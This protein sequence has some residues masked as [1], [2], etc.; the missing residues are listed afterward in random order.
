MAGLDPA[1]AFCHSP[2]MN[3]RHSYHAGNH[4]D[5][6][7]HIV[8]ARVIERLLRKDKPLRVIDAHA[9]AGLYD[10][11]GVEAGKT[12]EWQGGIGK[13][14]EE[15]AAPV[16]TLL[17]AYRKVVGELLSGRH[18]PGS[19]W[20]AAE[21]ARADD[22][23]VLNELHPEDRAALEDNFAGDRRVT[24]TGL[25]AEVCIKANLPPPERRGLILIDPPYEQRDEAQRAVRM[26]GQGIRRFATGC[27]I[28]WYPLKADD[29]AATV[30]DGARALRRPGTLQVELRVREPFAAGGLAGSGIIVVNPPWQLDDDMKLIAPALAER[31]GLGGWGRATV[32][33][34]TPPA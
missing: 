24:V 25:D 5:V 15:F 8:L 33:W 2:P 4:A 31:L 27:Y 32:T 34:L 17:S 26:L 9:G 11:A 10:L 28:L 30:C 21:L 13:M 14:A 3:Y 7:K 18:Y 19:P 20:I 16:E 23:L 22:R 29:T 1:I 12:L 6:L